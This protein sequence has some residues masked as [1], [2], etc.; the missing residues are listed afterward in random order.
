MELVEEIQA[1]QGGG[2]IRDNRGKLKLGFF[3]YFGHLTSLEAE[4]CTLLSGLQHAVTLDVCFLWVEL[5]SLL[6]VNMLKGFVAVP[7]RLHYYVA[8][9]KNIMQRLVFFV[10]HVYR[11][12]NQ[13]ADGLANTAVDTQSH[14][15]FTRPEDLP[16][17]TKGAYFMDRTHLPCIRVL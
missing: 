2:V 6:L 4:T 13:L 16:S 9:I 15:A 11:E 5:D 12:G 8:T 14:R 7:W 17:S 1:W 10:S 3:E